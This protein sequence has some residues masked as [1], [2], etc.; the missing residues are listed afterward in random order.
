MHRN[1]KNLR[2]IGDR[3]YSRCIKKTGYVFIERNESIEKM[4]I[5]NLKGR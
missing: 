1:K 5:K 3:E 4:I 2:K